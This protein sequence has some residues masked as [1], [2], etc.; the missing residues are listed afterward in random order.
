[1]V[2][3]FHSAFFANYIIFLFPYVCCGTMPELGKKL[4]KLFFC[5]KQRQVIVPVSLNA[6]PA[7]YKRTGPTGLPTH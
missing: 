2:L 1:M 5:R 7:T 4:K 6:N 3:F